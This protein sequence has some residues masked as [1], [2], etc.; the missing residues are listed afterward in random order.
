MENFR[1]S[2]AIPQYPSRDLYVQD[3][4]KKIDRGDRKV[5]VFVDEDLEG[6]WANS[7][8]S[9][10]SYAEDAT[11]HA[12]I[13]DDLAVC[14]DLIPG[15]EEALRH[16]PER[17]VMSLFQMGGMV[18]HA[19]EQGSSWAVSRACSGQG[20]VLPVWMIE[21]WLEWSLMNV[22]A[23]AFE[24]CWRLSMYCVWHKIPV[25]HTAPSMVQHLAAKNGVVPGNL[26]RAPTNDQYTSAFVGENNSALDVDWSR[27]ASSPPVYQ[28][29]NRTAY[30]HSLAY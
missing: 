16:V 24:A 28:S 14:H 25:W 18:G 21:D 15:I 5:T 12:V 1:V 11:H 8:P 13:E 3:M 26:R 6:V 29:L 22:K 20:N 7:M 10:S 4:L 30:L 19:V 23:S 2:L 27:R 17:C 9:W